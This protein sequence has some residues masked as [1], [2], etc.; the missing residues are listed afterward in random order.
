MPT[1][2]CEAGGAYDALMAMATQFVEGV[3]AEVQ[4]DVYSMADD[5]RDALRA[6]VGSWSQ[7]EDLPGGR[8][9][10]TYERGWESYHHK[11]AEGHVQAVVANRTAPG[12]TH[13]IENGHELFVYGRDAHRRTK[14]RPHI[15]EA[16]EKARKR[17]LGG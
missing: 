15:K 8:E 16:Y 7:T 9:R 6:D 5:A 17:R 13:L 10:L 4:A 11:M 2:T 14:P 3:E 1:M 12:L